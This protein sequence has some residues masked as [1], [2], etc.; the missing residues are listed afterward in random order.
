MEKI[1]SQALAD[2]IAQTQVKQIILSPESL[3]LLERSA[4]YYGIQQRT[5]QFWKNCTIL[6][7]TWIRPW[8]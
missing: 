3:W 2:N 4:S 8:N 6:S 7:Q 5:K 1:E